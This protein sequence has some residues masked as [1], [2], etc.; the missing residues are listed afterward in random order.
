MLLNEILD[1]DEQSATR[2]LRRLVNKKRLN[3]TD[4]AKATGLMA[5]L[6][7]K[8]RNPKPGADLQLGSHINDPFAGDTGDAGSAT[9]GTDGSGANRY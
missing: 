3:N 4:K 9:V 6:K 7:A 1:N 8:R 2:M 5:K